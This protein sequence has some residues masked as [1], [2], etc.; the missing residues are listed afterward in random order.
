MEPEAN[1]IANRILVDAK[2]DAESIVL[3]ARKAAEMMIEEQKDLGRQ[4]ASERVAA[5]LTD[6]RNEV[7][8]I[9][10]A[11]LTE[12]KRKAN[13][14]VLSEKDRLIANVMNEAKLKLVELTKTQKYLPLLEKL[15][16]QA[17][18][19][20]GGGNMQVVLNQHD[21]NLPLKLDRLA[22]EIE[23]K[24]GMKTRLELS[25]ERLNAS[26][27]VAVRTPDGKVVV[28]NTFE[29][30]LRRREIDLKPRMAK[31]LFK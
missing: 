14:A 21:S 4:R 16:V 8:L 24:T 31:L 13:W 27:G 30:I 12:T 3:E 18:T 23:T 10:R 22:K 28:D 19:G 5:I 6:A 1:K 26:G 15:L 25:K 29:T 7:R 9:Q 20:L 17:G 11:T 2:E